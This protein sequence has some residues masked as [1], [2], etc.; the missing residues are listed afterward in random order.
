MIKHA[1]YL[2][3]EVGTAAPAKLFLP[4]LAELDISESFETQLFFFEKSPLFFA[5][6]TF[7]K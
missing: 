4:F 7:Q 5:F 1:Y 2:V 3:L 6:V